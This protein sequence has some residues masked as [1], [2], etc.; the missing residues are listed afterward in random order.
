MEYLTI[1]EM[2]EDARPRERLERSGPGALSNQELLAITLSTGVVKDGQKYTAIDLATQLLRHFESLKGVAQ[3]DFS[4]LREVAGIGPAKACQIMA[5]F[6]LGKRVA[7]FSG[8]LKPIIRQPTDV[9]EYFRDQ[10]SLLPKEV[11]RVVTLD[12]KNRIIKD[13]TVSEGTLNA[14]IVHPRDVF[15]VAVVNSAASLILLHNHPSGDPMP[16]Q[17][18]I[19]IT[20]R[21]A[22]VGKLMEIPVLDHLI[23]GGGPFVSLKEM[24]LL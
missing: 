9:F 3:A 19:T 22:E 7:M 1:K 21:L 4:Q 10:M 23:I 8:T 11:F 2:P 15:R 14:S 13:Q 6:E 5:A 18:D 12:T 17:E 20:R 16:S 24:N